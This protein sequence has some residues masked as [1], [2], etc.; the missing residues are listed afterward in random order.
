MAAESSQQLGSGAGAVVAD[1]PEIRRVWFRFEVAAARQLR[2]VSGET[3]PSSSLPKNAGKASRQ[4]RGT[5]RCLSR[6][7]GQSLKV[8]DRADEVSI[9]YELASN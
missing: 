6:T 9:I 1:N 8:C 7:D 4:R 2:F 5:S 3:A